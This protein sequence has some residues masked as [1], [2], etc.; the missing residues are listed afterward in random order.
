M[1]TM[2]RTE[3]LTYS[4]PAGE[5]NEQPTL[6]LDGVTLAIERGSFTVILG[7]NGSGKSTLAKTF[8]AV[9][10]PSGGRVYVDG[11]DT[12]D[13]T[14]LLE[15]RRRVGMVFQNPDNQI[16]ANVVEEDVAFAPENLGVPTEEIRRRVDDALRT[17]GMKK[18]A[19][20][21][22]HLLSGG[23]KQRIAIAGVLAMRPQ[24]IVLDEATAML[25]PIGRS[26]VI[27]TIERLNRDEGITVVLITHHM[28]EAEH[29]DR[30]IVM[31][32]GRV[33]MDGAPRE[34][35]A[36]VEKLKSIG[37]TVP[38]TV[39]LLYELRGAGCDLP[40]TAITVD[41]CADA[42]ARCF[43]KSAKEDN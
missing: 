13:E 31:N 30:V 40:L 33:A 22:P 21:A 23:Q 20:H 14:L 32:E 36:Q 9:L 12:T 24:C 28:N 42:I 43:G 41:E 5:E 27:S 18:F 11:M 26:E 15:I 17:V 38:D 29:A 1:S 16:V 35:F 34:V 25:D 2:L 39:E 4:Y 6:A 8:N 37:L 7:H 19:K 3:N 10:L